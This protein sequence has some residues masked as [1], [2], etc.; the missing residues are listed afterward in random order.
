MCQGPKK[1]GF[2]FIKERNVNEKCNK[3][4]IFHFME[5]IFCHRRWYPLR[6][7]QKNKMKKKNKVRAVN[8]S[9]KLN[10][11]QITKEQKLLNLLS[12]SCQK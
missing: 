2:D 1:T 9:N 5:T 8:P 12:N 7:S 11:S 3:S 4:N 6:S 10:E